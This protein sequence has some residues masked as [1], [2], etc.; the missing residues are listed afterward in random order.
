MST[1]VPLLQPIEVAV[2]RRPDNPRAAFAQALGFIAHLPPPAF[3]TA[4]ASAPMTRFLHASRLMTLRYS[5]SY[6]SAHHFG[7][8][9]RN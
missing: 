6:P 8:I 1:R 7:I 4:S 5:S 2:N 3:I 9:V